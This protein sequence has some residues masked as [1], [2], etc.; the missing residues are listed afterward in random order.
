MTRLIVYLTGP[1]APHSSS[2]AEMVDGADPS[3]VS[4]R[5]FMKS[6]VF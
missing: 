2:A 4:L 3:S 5:T 1:F 6:N